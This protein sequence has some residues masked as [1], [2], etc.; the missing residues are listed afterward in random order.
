M[1]INS[2]VR[3]NSRTLRLARKLLDKLGGD[4]EE[5]DIF[6]ENILPMDESALAARD[7]LLKKGELDAP[8]FRY[9]R[10]FA[11]ADII[12]AAAPFWDLSFPAAF[13]SYLEAI[14]VPEITFTYKTG[15]P[16]GLCRAEKLYYVTTVGGPFIP[17]F[18]YGYV[19]ALAENFFGIGDVRCIYAENL[20]IIGADT[21]SILDAA[22][23]KI[24]L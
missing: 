14:M 12:A 18:G 5:L 21:D 7:E 8:R 19:K 3:S 11:N 13:K 4:V 15:V 17:D 16:S 22:A 6:K 1:F 20:D 9:A 23:E 10:Q 24:A 2:C